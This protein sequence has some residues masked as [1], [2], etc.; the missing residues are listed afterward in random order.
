MV[1][2]QKQQAYHDAMQDGDMY[3]RYFTEITTRVA[4]F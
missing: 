2:E 3:Q 1:E 4:H